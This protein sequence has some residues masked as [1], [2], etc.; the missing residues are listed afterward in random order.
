M[1]LIKNESP[2]RANRT[3]GA[4]VTCLSGF[5]ALL[6]CPVRLPSPGTSRRISTASFPPFTADFRHM[7]AVLADGLAALSS[8]LRHMLSISAD[9]LAALPADRRVLG[10]VAVP[11]PTFASATGWGVARSRS[12]VARLA[13]LDV[14]LV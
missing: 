12:L 11:A 1:F 4:S 7:A 3:V 9:C 13:G 6:L 14:L 2:H 8:D 10:A 5:V